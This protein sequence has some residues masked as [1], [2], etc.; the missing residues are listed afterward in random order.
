MDNT[1]TNN[2]IG[3]VACAVFLLVS[4][5]CGSVFIYGPM[6]PLMFIWPWLYRR[7]VEVLASMWQSLL[8]VSYFNLFLLFIC[9]EQCF[10]MWSRRTIGGSTKSSINA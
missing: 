5:F 8:V 2:V 6:L 10:L 7:V 3:G 1:R 9:V 4:S